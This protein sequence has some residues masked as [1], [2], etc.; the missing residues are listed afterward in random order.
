MKRLWKMLSKVIGEIIILIVAI[1]LLGII[2]I[3]SAARRV[4]K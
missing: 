1:I 2:G 4:L 3:V